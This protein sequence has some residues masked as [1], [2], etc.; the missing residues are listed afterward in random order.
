MDVLVSANRNVGQYYM[1]IRPFSDSSAAPIDNI[2]TGIFQYTNSE[3]GLNASLI[4]L[5]VM[6]DTDAMI[7]FLNQIRNTNV[8]QNP[9]INVPADKDIKRRVF[10]ALAVNNLP[11]S[12]CVVGSRLV[13]TLNNVSYVSPSI[14]IL[15]AYYNRNMS[16]VYTEDFPLNPP[17]IYDFTGNLT[18]LNTPV[19]EGTRVIVVNYGEGVEM[20]LQ[21]TQ[22]GAG[23]SHPIHL[24][25]FS[26]YWVG[27]GFGNFNN[28][29]DPSTYNLVDPPLINT[30]HVPG[31]RWVAIRFFATNPGVWFMHCHLERHSSWGMDTVL[32]VRNG[33]TKKTSIRPPPSTMPRCPG[34]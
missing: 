12:T 17:V 33:K 24:H 9:R 28:K 5:P 14:D 27:T 19:E 26:F 11:C 23:G 4:T 16:G 15:Q 13:A 29:T 34:T 6:N 31:R 32:I 25:G 21:A 1:A 22:M 3:G 2:T 18:N 10:I 30:V 8:S 20:V 7:N